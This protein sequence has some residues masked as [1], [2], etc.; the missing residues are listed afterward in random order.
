MTYLNRAAKTFGLLLIAMGFITGSAM[1]EYRGQITEARANRATN[2]L[3][4]KGV[5]ECVRTPGE[6]IPGTGLTFSDGCAP[7]EEPIWSEIQLLLHNGDAKKC[8]PGGTDTNTERSPNTQEMRSMRPENVEVVSFSFSRKIRILS[9]GGLTVCLENSSASEVPIG[10]ECTS[11]LCFFNE[12][13]AARR[14]QWY[15]RR[16]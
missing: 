13:V 16:H 9:R 15:G 2:K 10:D 7:D 3:R 11:G 4:V 6:I 14:V 12:V 8:R 1:A 5:I